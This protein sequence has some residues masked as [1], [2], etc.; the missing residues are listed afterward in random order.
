MRKFL[1]IFLLTFLVTGCVPVANFVRYDVYNHHSFIYNEDGVKVSENMPP[2]ILKE[3][4]SFVIYMGKVIRIYRPRK[5]YNYTSGVLVSEREY[6]FEIYGKIDVRNG[7]RCYYMKEML[8]GE[9]YH[10]L[11]IGTKK[12]RLYTGNHE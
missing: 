4:E 7:T 8:N 9:Y 10:Y 6:P 12:Y 2:D 5:K 11:I 3:G 1:V